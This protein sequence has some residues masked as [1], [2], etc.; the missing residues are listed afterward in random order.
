MHIFGRTSEIRK[1]IQTAS[2]VIHFH[3]FPTTLVNKKDAPFPNDSNEPNYVPGKFRQSEQFQISRARSCSFF[4]V[5]PDFDQNKRNRSLER[6]QKRGENSAISECITST[7]SCA[8]TR[9]LS[10]VRSGSKVSLFSTVLK[11]LKV[12]L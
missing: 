11:V 9:K 7:A 2:K 4:T 6:E 12:K 10:K 1:G 5:R 8:G 3:S